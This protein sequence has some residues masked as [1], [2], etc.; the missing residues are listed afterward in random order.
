MEKVL[1]TGAT[2]TVGNAIVKRLIADGREVSAFVRN[3]ERAREV[4]PE[5]V[6]LV[7]GDIADEGTVAEAVRGAD[8][9]FHSAGM[10][11]QWLA[12][13][14]GFQSVNVGGTQNV[15]RGCIASG[16]RLAYTSTIDVFAWTPGE[17]FDET[18]LDPHPRPTAYER[19]KQDADRIVSEALAHGLDAVFLHPSAVYGQAPTAEI[20]LNKLILDLAREK[21]PV[22]M[23]GGLPPVHADDVAAGHLLAAATADVGSRFILAGEYMTLTAIAQVVSE[24]RGSRVPRALPMW[25]AAGVAFAGEGLSK[26]TRR[27]PLVARGEQVFL[28]SHPVP[29]S[30]KVQLELD[31]QSRPF[32]IGAEQTLAYFIGKPEPA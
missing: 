8:V 22:L 3:A 4:L 10:P 6:T 21:V 23:K 13:K 7:T 14:S 24:L 2:G 5:S 20:A 9:V 31:W 12:R 15:V 11:E 32:E 29:I 16:S 17:P 19:S 30:A 27:P 28:G 18:E 25:M 26:L 1:V